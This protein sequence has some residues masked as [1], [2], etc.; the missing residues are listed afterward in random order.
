ME[1]MK[2]KFLTVARVWVMFDAT[3]GFLFGQFFAG[4]LDLAGV[5]AGIFGLLAGV[6]SAERFQHSIHLKRLVRLWQPAMACNPIQNARQWL[7]TDRALR[8]DGHGLMRGIV[9]HG[10]VLDHTPFGCAIEHEVHRPDLIG[11]LRSPQGLPI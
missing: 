4:R 7:S 9:H 8:H 1:N 11:S 6:L 10:Q 2:A 3:T 5:V